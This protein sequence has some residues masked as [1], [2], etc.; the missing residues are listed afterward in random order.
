MTTG[1]LTSDYSVKQNHYCWFIHVQYDDDP[2]NTT[3]VSCFDKRT[4]RE[5]KNLRKN[6]S[7][8]DCLTVFIRQDDYEIINGR[9]WI[10]P[11]STTMNMFHR[12]RYYLV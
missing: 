7:R 10:R 6:H 9:K 1:A 4:N 8:L 5:C 12:Y 2:Y 3:A 11:L